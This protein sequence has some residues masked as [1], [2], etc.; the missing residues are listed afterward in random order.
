MRLTQI[1]GPIMEYITMTAVI[2]TLVTL[3]TTDKADEERLHVG[4]F[5]DVLCMKIRLWKAH[6][7]C[8]SISDR[9][10]SVKLWSMDA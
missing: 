5:A 4:E 7:D 6:N 3:Y 1:F 2:Q 10:Q 9:R 8:E